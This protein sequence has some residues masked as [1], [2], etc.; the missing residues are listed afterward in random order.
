[1]SQNFSFFWRFNEALEAF[2]F[3]MWKLQKRGRERIPKIFGTIL[4]RER[5]FGNFTAAEKT[6][7]KLFWE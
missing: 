2:E 4:T 3:D 6:A 1:L 7:V 5:F